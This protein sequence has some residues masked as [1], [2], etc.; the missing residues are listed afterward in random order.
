VADV[1][2]I[3]PQDTVAG[4]VAE[5]VAAAQARQAEREDSAG[6]LLEL[7]PAH[8]QPPSGSFE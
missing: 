3:D 2:P 7:P 8:G 1:D 5:A 6:M 4:T